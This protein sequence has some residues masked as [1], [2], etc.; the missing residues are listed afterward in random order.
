MWKEC[1]HDNGEVVGDIAG[2]SLRLCACCVFVR[3]SGIVSAFVLVTD[4]GCVAVPLAIEEV[5]AGGVISSSSGIG[6]Q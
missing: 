3:P 6:G 5:T 1:G 4:A 2:E